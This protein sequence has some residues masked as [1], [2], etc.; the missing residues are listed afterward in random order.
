MT[1]P[2]YFQGG[3]FLEDFDYPG[4]YGLSVN[5]EILYVG[6][7]KNIKKRIAQHFSLLKRRG[8]KKELQTAYDN[9]EKITPVCLYKLDTYGTKADLLINENYWISELNPVCNSKPALT[10][11]PLITFIW[12]SAEARKRRYNADHPEYEYLR[13][14]NE[15]LESQYYESVIETA[16]RMFTPLSTYEEYPADDIIDVSIF[17]FRTDKE[18]GDKI[19]KAAKGIKKSVPKYI[20]E[21]VL[22][23]MESEK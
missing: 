16:D 22:M 15:N 4:V 9:G 14:F 13:Y 20:L 17:A 10:Q 2:L 6:S 7:S 3:L 12:L 5:G 23:R 21:A 19:K 8:H 18:L 11:D 1:Y